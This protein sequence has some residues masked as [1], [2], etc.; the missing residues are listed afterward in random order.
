MSRGLGKTERALLDELSDRDGTI[1]VTSPDM[2][3]AEL[4]SRRRAAKSLDGKG[5]AAMRTIR[6]GGRARTVLMPTEL[7]GRHDLREARA[8]AIKAARARK[9]A[10]RDEARADGR[11]RT[12]DPDEA[13]DVAHGGLRVRIDG[14]PGDVGLFV[15][16]LRLAMSDGWRFGDVDYTDTRTGGAAT[17]RAEWA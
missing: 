6:I 2:S 11:L 10:Q 4:A 7:A 16:A 15:D 3:E 13:G 17:V 8:D 9:D 5:L 12:L 14:D 1:T